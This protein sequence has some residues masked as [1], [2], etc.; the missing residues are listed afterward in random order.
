MWKAW[1]ELECMGLIDERR[2]RVVCVQSDATQP[3][4]KAWQDGALDTT[5]AEA[6]DTDPR[7]IVATTLTY[8]VNQQ[9]RMN[10]PDYR[11][12]GLP[13]TS[14]H[15]ESAVKQINQRVKGSEKF[16]G[17]EGGEALLQLRADQLSDT[18]PLS[19]YWIRRSRNATGTRTYT[20][21]A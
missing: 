18:Q 1:S 20:K 12:R 2:P 5:P 6:G 9:S 14:S 15:I 11:R 19:P 17:I 21:A 10:Y 16:W 7:Q 3:L 13:V 8:L 4:V